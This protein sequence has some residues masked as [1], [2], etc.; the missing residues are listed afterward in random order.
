MK[1]TQNTTAPEYRIWTLANIVTI[2]RVILVPLWALLASYVWNN[3]VLCLIPCDAMAQTTQ[4]P[5]ACSCF[6]LGSLMVFLVFVIL[7]LSDKLDGYLAR[8]RN[9][10]TVFGKFLDPIADKILVVTALIFLLEKSVYPAWM[11]MIIV[12]REFLISALRMLVASHGVVVAA[13]G[14]G[15]VKT[16]LTLVAICA[17]LLRPCLP[18][19]NIQI[20][21]QS[22]GLFELLLAVALTVWSGID[23]IIKSWSVITDGKSS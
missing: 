16:A 3:N 1:N 12:G 18:W 21:I 5:G 8:S 6:D 22:V 14:L 9:E 7:S 15:K 20:V 13:S 10:I 4:Q 2:A 11:L 19:A 17:L 23:Y